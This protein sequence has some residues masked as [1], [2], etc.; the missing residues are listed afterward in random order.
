MNG[1]S[2]SKGIGKL[3]FNRTYVRILAVAGLLFKS[4]GRLGVTCA[5]FL[6]GLRPPGRPV[7]GTL[8][9]ALAF[10][11]PGAVQ[12]PKRNGP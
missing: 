6:R 12:A 10:T 4:A 8:P 3:R 9:R 11:P 5:L 2:R 7:P 1:V